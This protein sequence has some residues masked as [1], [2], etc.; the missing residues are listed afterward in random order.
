MSLDG[1]ANRYLSY[2]RCLLTF[3]GLGGGFRPRKF[4]RYDFSFHDCR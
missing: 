2:S 4:K 1:R 3:S